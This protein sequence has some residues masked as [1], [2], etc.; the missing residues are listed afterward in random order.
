MKVL[1]VNTSDMSGGAAKAATRIRIGVESLGVSTQMFVKEKRSNDR[2]VVELKDFIPQNC[3]FKFFDWCT[4]KVKNKWQHHKWRPYKNR[5]E[6]FMSD[7]RSMSIHGALHKLDYDVLHLHWINLRFLDI[8]ELVKIHKP[9]VWTLHDSWP[10]CGVCHY[11][12]DC[13]QYK[14]HC[15]NCPLLRSSKEKDLAYEVF[16]KKKKAYKGLDL[17]IVS[18]SQWLAD[19]AR[20]SALLSQFPVTVISNCLDTEIFSP[21]TKIE[22]VSRWFPTDEKSLRKTYILYGAVHAETDKIKGFSYLLSVFQL[23]E[24][25]YDCSNLELLVF[26]TDKPINTFDDISSIPVRYLG[27]ID[28][29]NELSLLYSLADVMVVPSISEVFGQTASEA[30]SCGTPVVAFKCT[31][32]QYVVDETCGYLAEP[33]STE[34]MAKG[35]VWCIENNKNGELSK[36]ARQ[37]ALDNYSLE[38]VCQQYLSLYCSISK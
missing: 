16:E 19:C 5:E 3:A 26:G 25:Q 1:F 23:L 6:Y 4:K 27:F 30:M 24:K 35:I 15:G 38:K 33:Y 31:G 7:L 13:S 37:K 20:Q 10:F 21:K 28:N 22:A 14:T 34:D 2:H 29:D 9:I 12:L 18:P 8:N 17:H 11:F 36:N 32:I